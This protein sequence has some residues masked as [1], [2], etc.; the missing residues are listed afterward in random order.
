MW[1]ESKNNFSIEPN[2][3]TFSQIFHQ[4][5]LKVSNK[6][7]RPSQILIKIKQKYYSYYKKIFRRKKIRYD[8]IV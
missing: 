3:D 1:V 2:L 5:V 6:I 4:K 7:Q 8:L